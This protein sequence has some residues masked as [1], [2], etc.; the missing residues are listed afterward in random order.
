MRTFFWTE[1]LGAV[2]PPSVAM[3]TTEGVEEM[4]IAPDPEY[5]DTTED[6][7][8]MDTTEEPSSYS[9]WN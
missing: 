1:N 5:M 9:H 7:E 2:E 4:D 6:P 8:Y 3:D